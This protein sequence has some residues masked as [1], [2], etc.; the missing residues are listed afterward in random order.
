MMKQSKRW[1][2]FV[3]VLCLMLSLS[4]PSAGA[5]EK[6]PATDVSITDMQTNSRINPIGIDDATPVFSWK[7]QSNEIG[8]AQ[9]AYQIV[10]TDAKSEI[11]WDSDKVYSSVSTDI[12]YEGEGLSAKTAYKWSL[13]VWDQDGTAY[14]AGSASFET[15]LMNP[16]QDAW[17]GAEWIGTND[18][19]LDAETMK[20]FQISF[21][22]QL[23]PGSTKAGIIYGANDPRMRNYTKNKWLV[24]GETYIYVE[25]DVS[26]ALDQDPDTAAKINIYRKGFCADDYEQPDNTTIFTLDLKNNI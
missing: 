3:L 14:P 1:L 22:M 7:M 25:L 17:N 15:G 4:V 26:G 12:H 21:D 18:F 10:V 2:S 11:V 20:N 9:S 8:A 5:Q 19:F 16:S 24:E 6:I 23:Q 13:T